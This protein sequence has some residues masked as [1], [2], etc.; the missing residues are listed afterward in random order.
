M[1]DLNEIIDVLLKY[2]TIVLISDRVG[3]ISNKGDNAR[4]SIYL[5]DG[6]ISIHNIKVYAPVFYIK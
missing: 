5:V 1:I 4:I 6:Y 3:M 2:V